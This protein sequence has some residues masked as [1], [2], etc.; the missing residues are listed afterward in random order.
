M[1]DS[2]EAASVFVDP[3]FYFFSWYAG[4]AAGRPASRRGRSFVFAFV[5]FLFLFLLLK[6]IVPFLNGTLLF[7][8]C[9]ALFNAVARRPL[10]NFFYFFSWCACGPSLRVLFCFAFCFVFVW[11]LVGQK[12]FAL[13]A[14]FVLFASSLAKTAQDRLR[15]C[16][17]RQ[18]HRP[19][20][21]H[22]AFVVH[23]GV[24]AAVFSLIAPLAPV[25]LCLA[26][27]RSA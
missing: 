22:G 2:V 1:L 15:S 13:F 25:S 21:L 6:I 27:L 5:L 8:L 10:F 26:Q 11:G 16:G 18:P 7:V 9:L 24:P 19:V 23:S 4:G 20:E 3:Q 12:P 14:C 17:R